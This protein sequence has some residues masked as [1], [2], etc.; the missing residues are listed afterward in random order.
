M[1]L[2]RDSEGQFNNI[3]AIFMANSGI[4]SSRQKEKLRNT[5]EADS[6]I[7]FLS[8]KTGGVFHFFV[9]LGKRNDK[10]FFFFLKLCDFS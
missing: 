1:E 2:T 6:S 10:M 8:V 5:S 9:V 4:L 3:W 7:V